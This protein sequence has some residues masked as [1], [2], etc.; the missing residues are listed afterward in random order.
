MHRQHSKIPTQFI[1]PLTDRRHALEDLNEPV[2]DM[3][4]RDDNKQSSTELVRTACESHGFF[5][6]VNH[7]A[8]PALIA[9][10]L[11]CADAFFRLP[12]ARKLEARRT[13]ERGSVSGYACAHAHR[14]ASRLPWKETLSFGYG[15]DGVG[16]AVVE[17]FA[18]IL[19][20]DFSQ[21]GSVYRRYCDAMRNVS[22]AV[23]EVLATSLGVEKTWFKRY[24]EEGKSIMRLNHYPPCQEPELTLGTGPHCDPAVLTVLYQDQVGGLEIFA[25]N[26]WRSI[27]PRRDALVINIGDT[28]MALSDGRYKSCLH[29]AVVNRWCERRSLA[30]FLCPRDDEVVRPPDNLLSR[31]GGGGGPRKYPDFT[32]WELLEFTQQHYRADTT[33]LQA[34]IQWLQ[35]SPQQRAS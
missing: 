1:W 28:F 23:M 33:T 9:D 5:Q 8:E 20:E 21:M 17:Y 30:F 2:L 14:F 24:F 10:A 16:E 19:G 31:G 12:L 25:D 26:E 18:S 4:G 6:V 34:F 22:T 3:S 13:P 7:G 29:R 32:W 15:N 35:T 27:R 11:E